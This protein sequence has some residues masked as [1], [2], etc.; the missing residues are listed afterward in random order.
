MEYLKSRG[1]TDNLPTGQAGSI[2]ADFQIGYSNGTLLNTIPDEGDILDTL[3]HIG[4]LNDKGHRAYRQAGEMFYGSVVFPI[5]TRVAGVEVKRT[6]KDHH[7]REKDKAAQEDIT[8]DIRM[9]RGHYNNG[10]P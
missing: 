7:P 5:Y 8:P 9:I 10:R 2:F 3:K 1:I 6:H 4:I